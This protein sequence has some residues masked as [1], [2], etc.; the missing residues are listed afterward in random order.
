MFYGQLLQ[1]RSQRLYLFWALFSTHFSQQ[2]IQL[3]AQKSNAFL[4]HNIINVGDVS[5]Y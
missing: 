4:I 2:F 1:D 3:N 5:T